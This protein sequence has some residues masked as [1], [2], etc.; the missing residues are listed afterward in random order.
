MPPYI[1][2]FR[3][4]LLRVHGYKTVSTRICSGAIV[5]SKLGIPPGRHA[6][7]IIAVG[8]VTGLLDRLPSQGEYKKVICC[9][10]CF[11]SDSP[12]VIKMLFQSLFGPIVIVFL[13]V[14]YCIQKLFSKYHTNCSESLK[15][16]KSMLVQAFLLALLFSLQKIVLGA[17]SLV[18]CVNVG[19]KN[20][21]YIQG[22]IE[23]YTWWQ[24]VVIFGNVI[25]VLFVL[26]L[27]PFYVQNKV[28]STR[29]FII[30]CILPIPNL[31]YFV[32]TQW[33]KGGEVDS[34]ENRTEGK[35]RDKNVNGTDHVHD[36]HYSGPENVEIPFIDENSVSEEMNVREEQKD[37]DKI[38]IDQETQTNG[39]SSLE[40]ETSCLSKDPKT[41]DVILHTLLEQYKPLH[42]CGVHF[43]W[44]AIH[45]LYR[46]V[47]VA[48]NT[49]I[50]EPLQRL[51]FMTAI[52]ILVLIAHIFV[53]PYT[54]TF[55]NKTAFL[56]YTAN[57]CI[58]IINIFKTALVTFDCKTNCSVKETL[59]W[60]FSLT[61]N[62]LLIYLPVAAV[63]C[64]VIS[65]GLKKSKSKSKNE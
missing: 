38:F 43:T 32:I 26:S 57:L 12:A 33:K 9:D 25:P 48:C 56:S 46:V 64:W 65:I 7:D 49:Y 35:V 62:I 29:L 13:L 55:A 4:V 16:F 40:E 22:D 19:E 45:K 44:L 34:E 20:V 18:Q 10:T 5:L 8:L 1:G 52:L 47:L 28:M 42:V 50:T 6:L 14:I 39:D 61:E 51:W 58:A 41:M 17:F 21:L 11:T 3:G 2:S 63:V 31:I 53:K 15:V 37:L 60:Y 30:T 54:E 24:V 23:C 36:K 27:S 59:L